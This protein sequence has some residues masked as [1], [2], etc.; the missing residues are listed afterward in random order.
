MFTNALIHISGHCGLHFTY[1]W[2]EYWLM[3]VL[4]ICYIWFNEKITYSVIMLKFMVGSC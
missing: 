1:G 2:H 3:Q 4:V